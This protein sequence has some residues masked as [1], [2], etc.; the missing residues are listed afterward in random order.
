MSLGKARTTLALPWVWLQEHVVELGENSLDCLIIG[1]LDLGRVC[2]CL[3]V[4][5]S[6]T[7]QLHM[8]P[9]SAA[10]AA[11]WQL[12]FCTASSAVQWSGEWNDFTT[13]TS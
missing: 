4:H 13:C 9:F 5:C 7:N 10:V 1:E 3:G 12:Q 6:K 2:H 11:D 8:Q